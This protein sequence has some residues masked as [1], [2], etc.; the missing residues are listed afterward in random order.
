M[1]SCRFLAALTAAILMM[2]T[3]FAF[4]EAIK[5]PYLHGKPKAMKEAE[6]AERKANAKAYAKANV[7]AKPKTGGAVNKKKNIAVKL[8]DINSASKAELKGVPGI[9]EAYADKIIAGR[10]YATKANLVVHN[11]LPEAVYTAIKDKI[12]AKQPYKDG[13]RNAAIYNGKK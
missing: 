13:A 3:G 10:P 7:K 2:V 4:A 1:H 5:D 6:A 8:V 12:R 11:I 9:S